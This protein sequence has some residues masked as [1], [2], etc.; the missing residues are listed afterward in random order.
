MDLHRRFSVIRRGQPDSG[1]SC[2]VLQSGPTRIASLLSFRS[3]QSSLAVREFRAAVIDNINRR[4][5]G[6]GLG[7]GLVS[8]L[9]WKNAANEVTDVFVGT[10]DVRC[11]VALSASEQLQL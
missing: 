5:I 1:E 3:V 2:I 9:Q 10:F 11:R 8:M 4:V 7:L 6:L